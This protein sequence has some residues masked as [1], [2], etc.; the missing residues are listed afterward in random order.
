MEP[1][2]VEVSVGSAKLQIDQTYL[3]TVIPKLGGMVTIVRGKSRGK[4]GILKRVIIE[5][6]IAVIEVDQK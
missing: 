3:E 6:G 2:I 4:N 1:Y 5:E